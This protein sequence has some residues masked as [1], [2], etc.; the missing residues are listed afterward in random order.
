M[1]RKALDLTYA[2]LMRGHPFGTALYLPVPWS[3]FHP[4]TIGYFDSTGAWNPIG[5]ISAPSTLP[6]TLTS[7]DT[8][9]LSQAPSQQQIWGPKLGNETRGRSVDLSVGIGAIP[10]LAAT[11][12]AAPFDISACFRFQSANDKGAVLLT[13]GPVVHERYY[14][15]EPFLQWMRQNA[16]NL[17]TAYPEVKSHGVWI[18]TS[19][20]AAKDASVNCWTCSTKEVDVGFSTTALEFGEVAPKGSWLHAGSA[21]GWITARSDENNQG[22]VIFFHGIRFTWVSVRGLKQEK[23]PRK[24]RGHTPPGLETLVTLEDASE[25]APGNIFE[26]QYEDCFE[27]QEQEPREEDAD[28][29]AWE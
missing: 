6:S 10:L 29:G 25:T 4:G 26:I 21:E 15:R 8:S 11:R 9:D 17:A 19:T 28:E 23:N 12:G 1:S 3:Q 16:R 14:H 27:R 5:D 18:V 2:E 7:I 22:N 13:S 20:W 24:F